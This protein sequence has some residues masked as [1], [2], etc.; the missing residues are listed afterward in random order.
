MARSQSY[1]ERALVIRTYDLG[2]ADRIIVFLTKGRGLVRGVAKGV[3]RSKSRFGSRLQP[4]IELDVQF[5]AGRSL[6]S[7]TGAD[8]VQFFATGIIEDLGRYSAAGAVLEATERLALAHVGGDGDSLYDLV[9]D[10]LADLQASSTPTLRLDAFLLQA[11]ELAGW[12]PSLFQCGNCGTP[13]PHGAFH[14]APG[15]ALCATCRLPGAIDVDPEVLHVMWLLIARQWTRAWEIIGEQFER[16]KGQLFVDN[17]HTL[18]RTHL[19]WHVE[20]KLHSLNVLDQA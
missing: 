14:P 16:G 8:T 11:M 3:R 17:I 2:E 1:R 20:R 6:E 7:I 12:A 5:Y 10:A 4:F 9:I 19:Q 13:G 15:G 18:T